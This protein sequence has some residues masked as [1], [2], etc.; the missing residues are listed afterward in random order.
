MTK[1]SAD[2]AAM[3][4][5]RAA[6]TTGEREGLSDFGRR[7][8]AEFLNFKCNWIA[9]QEEN[10]QNSAGAAGRAPGKACSRESG[11]ISKQ[12]LVARE[13]PSELLPGACSLGVSL[14]LLKDGCKARLS[15]G[16]SQPF[17]PFTVLNSRSIAAVA[18]DGLLESLKPRYTDLW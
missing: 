10:E 8:P 13:T 16:C 18:G 1:S 3:P 5:L 9:S 12:L 4:G 14:A 2:K 6:S 17:R 11:L 7:R 15:A